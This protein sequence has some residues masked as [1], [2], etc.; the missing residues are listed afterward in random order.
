MLAT[1]R[2]T[3]SHHQQ[4]QANRPM[5]PVCGLLTLQLY[6]PNDTSALYPEYGFRQIAFTGI[7]RALLHAQDKKQEERK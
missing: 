1:L 5:R 2:R 7:I 4:R 6:V 3:H